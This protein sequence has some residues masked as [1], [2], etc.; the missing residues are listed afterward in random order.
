MKN[1]SKSAAF[2]PA[3]FRQPK[4]DGFKGLRGITDQLLALAD[5]HDRAGVL[6]WCR[7]KAMLKRRGSFASRRFIEEQLTALAEGKPPH[8]A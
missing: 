8:D 5:R 6:A 2:T 4:S 1:W 7:I 3:R